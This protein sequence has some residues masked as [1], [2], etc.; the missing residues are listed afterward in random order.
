MHIVDTTK[1]AIGVIFLAIGVVILLRA[2]GA[3]GFNQTKQAGVL[4]LVGAIVFCAIGLGYL[5]FG[6]GL[7]S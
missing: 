5:N 2:R 3:R 7:F 1:F 4:F 6:R